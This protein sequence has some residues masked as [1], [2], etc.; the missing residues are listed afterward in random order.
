MLELHQ[1]ETGAGR[2][3]ALVAAV[4]ACP[5][6]GLLAAVAGENA[7]AERHGMLDGKRV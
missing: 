5:G 7:V 6:Q 4:D 1:G 3:A 2:I